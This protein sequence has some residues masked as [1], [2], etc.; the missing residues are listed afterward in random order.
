MDL[1]PPPKR[2]LSLE[3][4]KTQNAM[5]EILSDGL[6]HHRDELHALCGPSCAGV[7]SQHLQGVR[8][9]LRMF[10]QDIICELR[11]RTTYYRH[12]RLLNWDE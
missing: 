1:T 10:G 9:K 12:V 11:N 4:T 3:L 5:L 8:K 6:P 7:V 2:D